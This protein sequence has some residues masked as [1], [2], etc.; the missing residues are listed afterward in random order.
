MTTNTGFE[1]TTAKEVGTFEDREL[2]WDSQIEKENDFIL[3][4][5]GDY[6]FT[7]ADFER[8][9]HEGSDKLPPCNKLIVHL[10][11]PYPEAP[12]GFVTV[13]HNLFFH[14]RTEGMISAFLKGIGQK[15]KGEPTKINYTTLPGSTGRC[16]IGVKKYKDNDYNEI[17]K[18][19]EK[20]ETAKPQTPAAGFQ[21]GSF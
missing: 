8:A 9:R 2:D 5:A 18:I 10:R 4:P 1:E 21:A 12:E 13:K 11:I 6:S 17:K 7:V 3:L 19:Y 15:K 16:S 20:S 14:V